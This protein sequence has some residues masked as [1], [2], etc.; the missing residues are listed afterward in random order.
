LNFSANSAGSAR[1]ALCDWFETTDLD[2]PAAAYVCDC[3]SGRMHAHG[4]R[5]GRYP[6]GEEEKN[7]N[8]LRHLKRQADLHC[9]EGLHGTELQDNGYVV[10]V[11]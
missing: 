9:L 8:G 2:Q 10:Y 7:E 5:I 1:D 6:P 11:T 3:S 4:N